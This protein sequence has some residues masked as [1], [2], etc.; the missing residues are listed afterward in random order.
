MKIG[1]E[2]GDR[3]IIGIELYHYYNDRK[4][5]KGNKSELIEGIFKE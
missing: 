5:G 1:S 2:N 3:L 4:R